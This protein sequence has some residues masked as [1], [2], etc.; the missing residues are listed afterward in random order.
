MRDTL[1]VVGELQTTGM[2]VGSPARTCSEP[3]F[4]LYFGEFM[5]RQCYLSRNLCRELWNRQAMMV[6]PKYHLKSFVFKRHHRVQ[7]RG[8]GRRIQSS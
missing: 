7:A 4:A 6:L 5:V 8:A 2:R 3:L 1:L